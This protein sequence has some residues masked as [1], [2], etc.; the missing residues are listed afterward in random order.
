MK[1]RTNET[2]DSKGK[3]HRLKR[4]SDDG[5]NDLQFKG[6]PEKVPYKAITL[7][8]VL[9]IFGFL[10]ILIG[11]LLLSGHI[12]AEYSDRTWPLLILGSLMFIPGSY[13]VYIAYKA[14]KGAEGYSFDDIPEF[15]D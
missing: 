13:H 3:Y 15:D 12:N 4:T 14:W 8:C 1:R 5:F 10:L 2:T 7:A 11:S 6:P 9:F